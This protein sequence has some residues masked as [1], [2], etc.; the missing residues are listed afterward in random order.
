MG[1]WEEG[2]I[3]ICRWSSE[4]ESVRSFSILYRAL[5]MGGLVRLFYDSTSICWTAP[6]TLS[7]L[8]PW[9]GSHTELRNSLSS[10]HVS[11]SLMQGL[12]LWTPKADKGIVLNICWV[13]RSLD[14]YE[15][16]ALRLKHPRFSK[17]KLVRSD[18]YHKCIPFSHCHTKSQ[19]EK[20]PLTAQTNR[21]P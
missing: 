10:L 3:W 8:F 2:R 15:T 11:T 12:Q 19:G 1:T 4:D 16:R 5:G 18:P 9:E 14:L 21:C 17:Q 20:Y 7:F 13:F 6:R